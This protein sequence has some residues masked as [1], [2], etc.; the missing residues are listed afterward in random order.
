MYNP[1]R[2]A[3]GLARMAATSTLKADRI[4]GL[5]IRTMK[6]TGAKSYLVVARG[7]DGK[8][9]WHSLG[10]V[11]SMTKDEAREEARKRTKAIKAGLDPEGTP[12][13]DKVA[14]EWLKRH[15]DDKQLRSGE[16]IRRLIKRHLLPAWS[17]RDFESIRRGD[18]AGLL[19]QIQEKSGAR[20]AD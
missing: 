13:F 3:R 10:P 9:V 8:R 18:V 14:D 5:Y 20:S 6:A 17:G 4:P 19:D 16:E 11:R 12:T 7:K 15:V 1:K 2:L